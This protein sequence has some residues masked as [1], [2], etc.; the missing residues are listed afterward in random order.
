MSLHLTKDLRSLAFKDSKAAEA[1]QRFPSPAGSLSTLSPN[2]KQIQRKEEG[3]LHRIPTA[4]AISHGTVATWRSG[5]AP[6][7][8][9]LSLLTDGKKVGPPCTPFTK[10]IREKLGMV[11][12]SV[13]SERIVS[14][15][16]QIISEQGNR[17]EPSNM[18]GVVFLGA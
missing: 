14:K 15:M 16:G 2:G 8:K 7:P 6:F 9:I 18:R 1:F 13:P 5:G 10:L 11:T 12:T 3:V 4:D 17:I